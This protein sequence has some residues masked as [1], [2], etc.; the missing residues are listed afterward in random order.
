MMPRAREPVAAS[1]VIEGAEDSGKRHTDRRIS[2]D[3]HC[4]GYLL[5]Q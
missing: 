5:D 4:T 3:Q 2:T 1:P